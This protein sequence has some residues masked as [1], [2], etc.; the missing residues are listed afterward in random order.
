MVRTGDQPWKPAWPALGEPQVQRCCPEAQ[1]SR[2]AR[3]GA[4]HP[5]PRTRLPALALFSIS[6]RD[7]DLIS[8]QNFLSSFL[9]STW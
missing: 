6:G 2:C 9:I 4:D 5:K 1:P 7:E 3:A 8:R